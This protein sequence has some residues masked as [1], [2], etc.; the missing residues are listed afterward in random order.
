M[1]HIIPKRVLSEIFQLCNSFPAYF[2]LRSRKCLVTSLLLITTILLC[3]GLVIAQSTTAQENVRFTQGDVNESATLS[4][5]VPL[6]KYS[7]RGLDLP[8]SLSY[9]SNVW[10]IDHINAV[11]NYQAFPPYYVTQSVTQ[12]IYSE[13]SAAG[14]RS[15]LDLPKIQFPKSSDSYSYKGKDSLSINYPGCFGFRIARVWIHMPDGSTHEFRKSDAA[16]QGGTNVDTVGKFFAVDGSR[17]LYD[18]TGND[19]GMLY[20]PD[21]THYVLGHPLSYIIDR[22]GNTQTY[23]ERSRQWTDTIGRPIVNPLPPATPGQP[24]EYIYYLPGLNGSTL[25]YTFKWKNLSQVLTQEAGQPPTSL[26]Y[27]A[28]HYLPSPNNSPTDSNQ[29]NFPQLQSSQNE[30]LF[31]AEYSSNPDENYYAVPTLVVGK[32]AFG[33]GGRLFDPVVLAEVVLPD[34]TSYKFSYNNYGE[35][36]KI[37][38]PTGAYEKYEYASSTLEFD[39]SQQPYVQA[40]RKITSRKLSISGQ[41]DDNLEWK[42]LE[43]VGLSDDATPEGSIVSRKISVIAP[44]KTRTEFYKYDPRPDDGQGNPYWM[45]GLADARAGLVF[46][47]KI[48]STSP[49]GLGGQLLRREITQYEQTN[50]SYQFSTVCGQTSFTKSVNAYRNPRP[51]KQVSIFFE[52]S[53]PALSQTAI[54]GYDTTNQLTTGVDQTSAFT[55]HYAVVDNSIGQTGKINQIPQGNLA[56]YTETSYL[57]DSG[58]RDKNILG[59]PLVSKVLD[60]AGNIAYQTEMRYDESGF[61]PE[62]GRALPT[63][64]R[65]WDST[66]GSA[67]DPNAYLTTRAKFD[68]YGNRIEATDAKGYTTITQYDPVYQAFP[69]KLTTPVPDPT[70]TN[71][72]TTEFESV[73]NYDYMTGLTLSTTDANGQTTQMEYNDPFLRLTRVIPPAGGAGVITEYGLGNSEA[74]R[75]IKIK[76]QID[77][78]NWTETTGFYDGTGKT[79]KTQT[80]DSN[81]DVFI[82]TQ[83]DN[84]SRVKQVTNPYRI[85][86]QKFW[87]STDYDDLG[88]IVRMTVPDR[89]QLQTAYGLSTSGII[90]TTKTNT[91]EANRK[92]KGIADGLDRMVRVIEDPDGQSL[93]TDYVFDTLGNLRQT[94]QGE[95][96]RYFM[97]DSLGRVLY[98]KQPEQEANTL[99]TVT[100]PITRN[101]QWAMKFTYDN[102]SN[103]LS[104]VDARGI[105]I[106]AVYDRINR[107][108][109]RD[110]SDSTP[111][112]SF[113]YD[114]TGLGQVSNYSKGKTT[115]VVSSVSETRYT[116]FDNLGRVKSSQ[117]VT[118]GVAYNFADYSYDLA[119]N[120]IS[121]TYPSGRIVKNTLDA[122]GNLAK[123]ESQ[124][125]S[126][127][128]LAIYLDQIKYYAS[129]EVKESRLGN[130]RWETAI[131]NSRLQIKQIGLGS[132]STDTSLLKIE[133]DYGA[134]AQNNGALRLQKISA[135]G[136]TQPIVQSYT[137]D[138]LDRLQSSVETY[139]GSAQS[140]RQTFSYDR[141]GNRRFDAAN[142]TTIDSSAGAKYTNPFINTSDNRLKKD[143]DGDTVTD[144]DY[145][146]AGNLTLD[147]ERQRFAYDAENH[148]TKFFG[149]TNTTSMPDA[150]YYYDGEG[151]RVRKIAGQIETVFVYDAGGKLVAEYSNQATTTSGVSYLTADHL[152]SPRIITDRNGAVVSRHDYM[153]FGDEVRSGYANRFQLPGYGADDGIRQKFTSYERDTESG[154]DYA[155]A[156]YYNPQHGRFT[157]ADPLTASATIRNPQTFNR[158]SYALNSPYKFTDPL[159]LMAALPGIS[160]YYPPWLVG[161]EDQPLWCM[162]QTTQEK[163]PP[164]APQETPKPQREPETGVG[165]DGDQYDDT[166]VINIEDS[167]ENGVEAGANGEGSW[168]EKQ[169]EEFWAMKTRSLQSRGCLRQKWDE[170]L[171]R[172]KAIE[173]EAS[174]QVPNIVPSTQKE[175]REIAIGVLMSAAIDPDP[176]ALTIDA[177][178][179]V[180]ASTINNW[181]EWHKIADPLKADAVKKYKEGARDCVAKYGPPHENYNPKMF[182]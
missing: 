169:V 30:S 92:R 111:D 120:L 121:Q 4:L 82:E 123:V 103:L 66:K 13:Y 170:Y 178:K 175:N 42:Y 62:A 58:Y 119:G 156:R 99:F 162:T 14:W 52:G 56:R 73:V 74:T 163:P 70:G 71:G 94:I 3:A 77:P 147:V 64:S 2:G 75:Y 127:S 106:S 60:S 172:F 95:Q 72:S 80:K 143:Q 161:S 122:N 179:G 38:Y 96:N 7:G 84:M 90:G 12:A 17:M 140:W 101:S 28:S 59:L 97:C 167:I 138:N 125:S 151:K 10:R 116:A 113:Y 24:Q 152:G 177:A 76:N 25:P 49:D 139:N 131:Y 33:T 36:D 43:A 118:N 100:D 142:T 150:T 182:Q 132:S 11:K 91:D 155:Q 166:I 47:K 154:L 39:Q 114:G 48:Y 27:M 145:D 57:N 137:Y 63:S 136:L 88:R 16:Y 8:V 31:H 168:Q 134:S 105:S 144:F 149:K 107:P 1:K 69:V 108:I 5:G 44:D 46:Q 93:V 158:Y 180:A 104:S 20:M 32:G 135:P 18:S 85:G 128:P 51:V 21:G 61:S 89:A 133:Y 117:Q 181:I 15:S 126:S 35:L 112:V 65:V 67:S 157:S 6:G 130:G 165:P 40:D 171:K 129:G 34:G 19:T 115:K 109:L 29:G 68:T 26:K 54:Y 50:N 102:N 55:Y 9:S 148:Q 160:E 98:S 45:F 159:G 153:A 41:G 87:S 146:K 83:Y 23:D 173:A 174:R 37:V 53:G 141:Y 22:N 110:Y 86:E 79:V 176:V 78:N 81:G 124:K 164:P